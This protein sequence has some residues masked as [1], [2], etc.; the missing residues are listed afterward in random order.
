MNKT[1]QTLTSL[2]LA[3][4]L[5]ATPVFGQE[6]EERKI[7]DESQFR[8]CK[9]LSSGITISEYGYKSEMAKAK[10]HLDEHKRLYAAG[11]LI[12]DKMTPLSNKLDSYGDPVPS[13]QYPA[14]KQLWGEYEKLQIKRNAL[15]EQGDIKYKDFEVFKPKLDKL[16]AK[17]KKAFEKYESRSCNESATADVSVIKKHCPKDSKNVFCKG[18]SS[19]YEN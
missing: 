12:N 11:E 16:D 5:V 9:M 15:Y 4:S 1:K 8:I 13:A 14:Y 6:K 2:L 7:F 17:I 19:V 10:P 3:T 18:W